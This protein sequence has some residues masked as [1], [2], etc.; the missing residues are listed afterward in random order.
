MLTDHSTVLQTEGYINV[1]SLKPK[2]ES[3]P[4]GYF[5]YRIV[6]YNTVVYQIYLCITIKKDLFT[7]PVFVLYRCWCVIVST[8]FLLL[9][10]Y[11]H[12]SVK[13]DELLRDNNHTVYTVWV[14]LQ[15]SACSRLGGNYWGCLHGSL[16]G[17]QQERQ[18]ARSWNGQHVSRHPPLH[19]DLQGEALAW[20]Q[21]QNTRWPALWWIMC[22]S[23]LCCDTNPECVI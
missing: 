9:F 21:N 1:F 10:L 8:S 12:P 15:L 3:T 4:S 14:C 13:N 11:C 20:S 19:W 2:N 23:F 17:P 16:R 22:L 5:L 6:P 18:S 7:F